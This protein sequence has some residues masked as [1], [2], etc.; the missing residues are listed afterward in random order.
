[1][2]DFVRAKQYACIKPIFGPPWANM[3]NV[4]Q[5][6]T[7][8]PAIDKNMDIFKNHKIHFERAQVTVH[9]IAELVIL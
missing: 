3:T 9:R 7:F 4:S 2:S 1:M 8:T 5:I 6:F